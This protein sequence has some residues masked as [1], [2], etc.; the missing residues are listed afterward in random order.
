MRTFCYDGLDKEALSEVQSAAD[1]FH[2]WI[3]ECT[4]KYWTLYFCIQYAPYY[5]VVFYAD[6]ALGSECEE[7]VFLRCEKRL[8]NWDRTHYVPPMESF[9]N[10]AQLPAEWSPL[11][12]A[13]TPLRIEIIRDTVVFRKNYPN[14]S[15]A[16]EWK[17]S[18]DVGVIIHSNG[19]MWI[20]VVAD[21]APR[22]VYLTDLKDLEPITETWIYHYDLPEH[23]SSDDPYWIDLVTVKREFLP[24]QNCDPC[25]SL[26]T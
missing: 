5:C 2:F 23:I 26:Q 13:A 9:P 20:L 8:M 1:S 19:R 7:V 11:C 24:L 18:A 25:S 21:G 6:T 16:D 17:L 10:D 12:S 4:P 15:V 14:G 22:M 3:H